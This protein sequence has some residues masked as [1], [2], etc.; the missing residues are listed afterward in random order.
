M[1]RWDEVWGVI[2]KILRR[3]QTHLPQSLDSNVLDLIAP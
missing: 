1:D 3:H 2:G